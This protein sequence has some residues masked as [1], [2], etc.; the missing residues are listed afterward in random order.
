MAGQRRAP[1]TEAGDLKTQYQGLS[2]SEAHARLSRFG[3]NELPCAQPESI[4]RILFR[5]LRE[6]MLLLLVACGAI[7]LISGEPSE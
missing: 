1:N 6:P 7:Y 3:F 5:V 4:L 2:E